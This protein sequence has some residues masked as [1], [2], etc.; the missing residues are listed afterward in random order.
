VF[1]FAFGGVASI[2][3][4]LSASFASSQP[5]QE[6][7]ELARRNPAVVEAL[8]EP[9]ELG[10]G[11]PSGSLSTSPT[12]GSADVSLPLKGPNGKGRLF[13]V[14]EKEAGEWTTY[15]AEIEIPGRPGRIDLLE[16]EPEL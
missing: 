11:L 14:A 6:A 15:R 13:V 12:E 8:G 4:V 16:A 3:G 2:F 7:L 10:G 1:L 5:V 9:I